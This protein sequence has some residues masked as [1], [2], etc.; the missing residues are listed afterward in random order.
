MRTSAT[1]AEIGLITR[2]TV[3]ACLIPIVMSQTALTVGVAASAPLNCR[4]IWE[5]FGHQ[6]LG[7][8]PAGCRGTWARIVREEGVQ[9]SSLHTPASA[10]DRVDLVERAS[11]PLVLA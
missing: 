10:I 5:T 3:A 6:V 7:E 2:G 8:V 4:R 1:V 9:V 11:S